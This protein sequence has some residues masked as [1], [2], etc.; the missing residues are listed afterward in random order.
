MA[1]EIEKPFPLFD[2]FAEFCQL[3][4]ND[5][6]Q[7]RPVVIDLLRQLDQSAD[8]INS[9]LAVREFLHSY[10][11]NEGTFNSYRTHVERLLLWCL[12]VSRQPILSMRRTDAEAFMDFCMKPPAH[13]LGP[14][15]KSRFV[16]VGGRKKAATDTYVINDAWRPFNLTVSKID[17]KMAE[18][19]NIAA[20]APTPAAY[21][22]AQASIAQAFA[23]CQ[24]FFQFCI[25]EDLTDVNPFRA[26]KQKSRFTQRETREV[27]TRSLTPLQW[28]FV[29][30]T[31]ELMAEE[32]AEHE[33][34][35]FILV[36]LFSL[37]LRISDLVGRENWEPTMGSFQ[38]LGD[39]WWFYAV[40]KG[41][42]KSKVS[43]RQDYLK[44]LK[45]YRETL[46]LSPLPYSGEKTPL[47]RTLNGRAGLSDRH[48][49]ELIQ[50]VFDR[51]V[52]RMKTE[53]QPEE[54]ITNLRAASLHWLRHTS[55]TFDA[56][57]RDMKD[58][59]ADLGHESLSTTQDNYYDSLDGKRASSVRD[60][61]VKGH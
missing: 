60:L 6:S 61:R 44:Y 41:N 35:L 47:L 43:V 56:P 37:Y 38:K 18:E 5:F 48:V 55:A 4:F 34:T 23:A 21:K 10:F 46:S 49:R 14:V 22:M 11:G 40:R 3:N 58:L 29:I 32:D 17:R 59:Q 15:V 1:A 50:G 51:A 39:D 36:T 8:P 25:D 52:E 13:W 42:K 54:E 19:A 53:G 2:S 16:R 26:V 24:S 30:E 9:Y 27:G 7:E 31:A 28:D 45:R 57:H 33:R 20:P 12:L